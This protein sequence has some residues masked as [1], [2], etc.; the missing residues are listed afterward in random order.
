MKNTTN[1][2]SFVLKPSKYG[3]GVFAAHGIAKGTPLRLYGDEP[4]MA[5]RS[6]ERNKEDVPESLR[7]YCMDRDNGILIC[8]RDFGRM[9]VGWYINH[10]SQ[11]NTYR[12]EKYDWYAA[13]D[14]VADEEIVIDYN[15][16]EEPAE[17]RDE[18]YKE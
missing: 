9:E 1:E 3:V 18:Y 16:L 6:L 5:L 11:P 13:R 12:D 2:F 15:L 10:S 17:A 14:I 8:P 7:D 4:N